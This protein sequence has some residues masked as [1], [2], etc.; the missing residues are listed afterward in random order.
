MD[1]NLQRPDGITDVIRI[2]LLQ[3]IEIFNVPNG[4]ATG[5]T[6]LAPLSVG[7]GVII[8]FG[9]WLAAPAPIDPALHGA[10]GDPHSGLRLH[11]DRGHG[12][13]GPSRRSPRR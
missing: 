2:S 4:P 3:M 9:Q 1:L 13:P 10:L 12:P 8:H 7:A 5:V 11:G 6:S